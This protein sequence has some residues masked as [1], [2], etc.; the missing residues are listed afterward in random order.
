MVGGRQRSGKK[1][2]G[3]LVMI[4]RRQLFGRIKTKQAQN[5]L[6]CGRVSHGHISL[7]MRFLGHP[8]KKQSLKI[9][10]KQRSS[11]GQARGFVPKNSDK[12]QQNDRA[13]ISGALVFPERLRKPSATMIESGDKVCSIH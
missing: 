2:A 8:A 4:R 3:V 13:E 9:K 5:R 6:S 1:I 11:I 7:V 12:L 10:I